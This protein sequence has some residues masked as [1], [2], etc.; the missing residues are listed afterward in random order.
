MM[1][2]CLRRVSYVP[3]PENK[4]RS[5]TTAIRI[6]PLSR[7]SKGSGY[8]IPYLERFSLLPVSNCYL[9]SFKW[10]HFMGRG[11]NSPLF[12]EAKSYLHSLARI[13]IVGGALRPWFSGIMVTK[14]G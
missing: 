5:S 14:V 6:P 12:S 7:G 8:A 2:A 9:P 10:A 13:P 11:L 4:T 1:G 3:Y